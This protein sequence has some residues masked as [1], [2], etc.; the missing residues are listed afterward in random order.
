MSV[1][2]EWGVIFYNLRPFLYICD[3]LKFT[4]EIRY[5]LL[6]IKPYKVI[7]FVILVIW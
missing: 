4:T 1:T 3:K 2:N 5:Y 7:E 6:K